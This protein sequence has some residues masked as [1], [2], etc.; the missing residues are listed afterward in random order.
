MQQGIQDPLSSH[1]FEHFEG[2]VTEDIELSRTALK[3][4]CRGIMVGTA[5][6]IVLR[7]IDDVE[8]AITTLGTDTFL[9]VQVSAILASG[10]EGETPPT[11]TAEDITVFW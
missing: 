8:V 4:P 9:P 10:S 7:R 2:A 5:G 6:I 11:T 1:L 3:K